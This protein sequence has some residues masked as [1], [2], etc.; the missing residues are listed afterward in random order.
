MPT[1][2]EA[3]SGLLV[4]GGFTQAEVSS[5][6]N[7]DG[8]LKDDFET[9]V[10]SKHDAQRRERE[11]KSKAEREAQFKRGWK[12]SSET[13][14]K[15]FEEIGVDVKDVPADERA[16][17][18]KEHFQGLHKPSDLDDDKVKNSKL[19]R[20]AEKAWAKQLADKEAAHKQA[21]TDRDAKE[22]RER[23]VSTVKKLTYERAK[24]LKAVLPEDDTLAQNQLR[25]LDLEIDTLDFELSEDGSKVEYING[26]DGKRLELSTGAPMSFDAWS[27]GVVKK[28]FPLAAS[29]KKGSAGD[30]TKG[31]KTTAV[32]ALRK[33]ASREEYAKM[34]IE[35]DEKVTDEKER[36]QMKDE[37]KAMMTT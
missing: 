25:L 24:N 11:A 16:S 5:L 33:P 18:V 14:D 27:E 29:E 2:K 12:E 8:S 26:K 34:L 3:L 32:V 37:L 13:F 17:K 36:F 35:I 6:Y 23:T 9:V 22:Q 31:S 21:W 28:Y 1:E 10:N 7:E 20:E 15:V 30:I 4:K 19:Y